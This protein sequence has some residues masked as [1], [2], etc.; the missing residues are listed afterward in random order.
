MPI[1]TKF[2]NLQKQL[3]KLA[4][5]SPGA[6]RAISIEF[7]AESAELGKTT[8]V[9]PRITGNLR[10]TSRVIIEENSILFVTGGI[11]GNPAR[12]GAK[13]V[14]VDY[15]FFVNNGTSRF[16]G[17]FFMERLVLMAAQKSSAI[18]KE[19]LDSWLRNS[20]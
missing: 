2:Q 4:L 5:T 12:K 3:N 7:A 16:A 11:V 6:A 9:I 20:K 1:K 17:R 15:A 8:T 10:S 19:T 13:A 14:D 18:Y